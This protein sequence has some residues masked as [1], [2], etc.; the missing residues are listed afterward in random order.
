M[1][2]KELKSRARHTLRRHYWLLTMICLFAAF[3]GVEYGSSLWVTSVQT[4]QVSAA[5]DA[6]DQSVAGMLESLVRDVVSGDEATARQQV[7]ANEQSISQAAANPMLGRTR[8]VFAQMLNSF[9]SG[10]VVLSVLD[11]ARTISHSGNFAVIALVLLSLAV[12][13]FVWLFV[14]ESYLIVARR[15]TLE[16]RVYGKVPLRRFLYPLQTHRWPRMAWIMFVKNVYQYL[17][18]LTIVGGIIKFFSYF[19]VPYIVAENPTIGANEAIS[20][21]RRMMRGHKWECFVAHLSF[22]GWWLLGMASFG[23]V[24]VFYANGYRA[25]FFSEYYTAVRE[26][27]KA[28]GVKGSEELCDDAL[29]ARPSVET[30][31]S[32]YADMVRE[33]ET[34]EEETASA[35]VTRPKGL[36]GFLARWFGITLRKDGKVAAWERHEARLDNIDKGRDILAGQ[37]YPGRLAPAPMAFKVEASANLGATRSYTL[38]NLVMMF[39]IFCFVGWAWEVALAFISEGMFV[40]RG[41]LHGPWLPIY[42]T[43]GMIILILLKRLRDHPVWLFIGTVILCGALEYGS[44]WFLE[45]THDGQRWWDYSGYFLNLNGRICAEGL[46]V[47]G[48]GGLAIVYLLAP[49]LDNLLSRANRRIMAALA[50]V[51]VVVYCADQ[52]YSM[53]HPNMGAG[54]TDYKG[55]DTSQVAG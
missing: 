4:T 35:G 42:G 55:S 47:F 30:I 28:N 16:A 3:L 48:L 36:T 44:S 54:I 15:M 26:Q 34:A 10:S 31:E 11:A 22:V 23:L 49:A 7:A 53:G 18:S 50:I 6:G 40:N 25:A 33:I 43:G 8:G 19:M 12:Y 2:R 9:S 32:A 37:V 38:L 51:L 39:F 13:C 5:T 46:L 24:N 21:S 17:W 27:A 14:K 1:N 29:F 52:V 20:L 41:T 45:K